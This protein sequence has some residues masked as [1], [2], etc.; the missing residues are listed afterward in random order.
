MTKTAAVRATNMGRR[1]Q[2]AKVEGA[3]P[4]QAAHGEVIVVMDGDPAVDGRIAPASRIAK[5]FLNAIG[6]G[7]PVTPGLRE[8]NRV[9]QLIDAA[10]ASHR[11]KVWQDVAP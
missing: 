8:G 10:R 3:T 11:T 4:V 1:R 5:R 2:S 6:G 9:Q 7:Q